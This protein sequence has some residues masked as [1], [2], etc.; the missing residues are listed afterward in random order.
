MATWVSGPPA[1]VDCRMFLLEFYRLLILSLR[2]FPGELYRIVNKYPD[3]KIA[4]LATQPQSKSGG[5]LLPASVIQHPVP[6][7][8]TAAGL[9]S[10]PPN[11]VPLPL[12]YASS[13]MHHIRSSQLPTLL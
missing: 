6:P 11:T 5:S 8:V 13:S 12:P 7:S 4:H 9:P 2:G 1:G 3:A 10:S